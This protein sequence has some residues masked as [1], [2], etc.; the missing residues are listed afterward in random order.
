MEQQLLKRYLRGLPCGIYVVAHFNC[1]SW[2]D[3]DYRKKEGFSGK[4]LDELS[5]ILE[6]ERLRLIATTPLRLDLMTLDASV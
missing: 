5:S 1:A 2:S 6:T 4:L 3:T